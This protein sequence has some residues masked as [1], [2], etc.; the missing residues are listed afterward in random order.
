MA[1]NLAQDVLMSTQNSVRLEPDQFLSAG[2]FGVFLR[3]KD[4]RK[5]AFT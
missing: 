2:I 4:E 3:F 1:G 5:E